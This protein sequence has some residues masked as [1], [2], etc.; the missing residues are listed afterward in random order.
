LGHTLTGD[1]IK[2]SKDKVEAIR[3]WK[4]PLSITTVRFFIGFVGFYRRNIKSFGM[5]VCPLYDL[6]NKSRAF[7]WDDVFEVAFQELKR[8]MVNPPVLKL[9]KQGKLFDIWTDAQEGRP[10][11]FELVKLTN[12]WPTHDWEMYAIVHCCKH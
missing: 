5:I 7:Y 6:T 4:T 3:D 11:A 1:G 10:C 9:P 8:A 2:P 12:K